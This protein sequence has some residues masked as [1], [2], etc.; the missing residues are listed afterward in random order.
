MS[1]CGLIFLPG[2]G[3][4]PFIWNP[5][6]PHLD[7]PS[8]SIT[9]PS[10]AFRDNIGLNSYISSAVEQIENTGYDDI[11]FICHSIGGVLAMPLLDNFYG[12]VKGICGISCVTPEPGENFISCLPLPNRWILS[13][14]IRFSGT[15]PTASSIKAGL[16]NGLSENETEDVII[17]FRPE[18][19]RLYFDACNHS[20][21]LINPAYVICKL[22]NELSVATQHKMA[23]KM[24]AKHL[25][26]I[27]SGHLPMMSNPKK[28]ASIIHSYI[29]M[30]ISHN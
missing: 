13:L 21:R 17:N 29:N 3:L 18:S 1:K 27:E 28:L 9:Y 6:L 26:E 19:T 5:I 24:G 23:K 14:L 7:F 12:R 30:V 4:G 16:C 15:K 2:A 20:N 25:Y 22:D 8:Y 10:N 11:F